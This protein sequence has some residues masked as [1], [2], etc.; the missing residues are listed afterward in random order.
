MKYNYLA[1]EGNIGAG[2]TSLAKLIAEK[3]QARLILEQF[4]DNPFLPKFY[5]DPDRYS[6]PLELSFLASRYNQ[7]NRLLKHPDL[8]E[9]FVVTDYIFPKSLVFAG[10]TLQPDEFALYRQLFH[11]I[12]RN[13]PKPDL[14]V[15][16]YLSV[17]QLLNN[18]S[19]RGREY[20]LNIDGAYLR[21]IYDGYMNYLK[22]QSDMRILLIEREKID[23][24]NN[25]EDFKK[26]DKIIFQ[27]EVAPGLNRLLIS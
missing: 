21:K 1:I 23:F 8:F 15:F 27:T 18:I 7:L 5:Q 19:L 26:I 2:K 25:P 22:S 6:F 3:Y 4:E 17:D 9:T 16:L 12:D 13:L 10:V 11:M 20:E 24:I 14:L